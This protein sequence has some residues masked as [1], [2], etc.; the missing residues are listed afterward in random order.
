M[1]PMVFYFL[2]FIILLLLSISYFIYRE[3]FINESE[4]ESKPDNGSICA[5]DIDGTITHSIN[6]AAQAIA[7][8]K[9]LG[10][11]IAIVTARP[12]KWYDDLDLR[13]LGL[14][15]DDFESDFYHGEPFKCSF[16]DEKCLEDS[17]ANTKV[18]HLHTLVNKWNVNP[19][20]I[21]LFDDLFSNIEKAKQSGFS[22]IH[23]NNYLGGLPTDVVQQIENILT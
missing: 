18:K 8:C 20:R 9:E 19:K 13:A 12:T 17:I 3:K 22:T 4:S 14:T 11:K 2:F 10:S 23:A 1:I 5:F 7:K 6:I 16:T 15:K 21:I